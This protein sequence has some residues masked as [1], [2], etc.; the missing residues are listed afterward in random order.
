VKTAAI[1]L[2]LTG[3]IGSGK[4]TVA[5]MLGTHGA[6]VIDTDAISRQL[7][8]PSGSAI[9]AIARAF[10]HEFITPQGALDR[11]RMRQMIFQDRVARLRLEQILHP[12]IGLEA[13]RQAS[14]AQEAGSHCIVFDIP[15]LVESGRWRAIVDRVLVVDCLPETQISRVMAR[16]QI[17]REDV[18]RILQQQASRSQRLHAADHV[19]N[20]NATN[21]EQLQR[22]V[23]AFAAHFGL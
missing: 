23:Q 6:H 13:R 7:T 20:N 4:S 19:I 17:P 12:L 3:G 10:G 16:N 2:G 8:A 22:L 1:R 14:L 15:L 11:D 18:E 5:S 21:L 9:P